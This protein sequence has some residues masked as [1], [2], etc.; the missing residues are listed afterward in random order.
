MCGNAV[1]RKIKTK[2]GNINVQLSLTFYNGA[3]TDDVL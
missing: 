1:E 2:G 3:E